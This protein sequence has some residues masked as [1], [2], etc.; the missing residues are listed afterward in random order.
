M[1]FARGRAGEGRREAA[2]RRGGPKAAPQGGDGID[3]MISK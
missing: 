2:W 1:V 3:Q